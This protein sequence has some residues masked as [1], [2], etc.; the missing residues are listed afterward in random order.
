MISTRSLFQTGFHVSPFRMGEDNISQADRDALLVK[1]DTAFRAA[2]AIDAFAARGVDK[3]VAPALSTKF[4]DLLGQA[5]N[6]V[7]TVAVIQSRLESQVPTDWV[8][9]AVERQRVNDYAAAIDQMTTIMNT[10]AAGAKPG[11]P[12]TTATPSN[13]ILGMPPA[14]VYIGGTVVG[15]GLLMLLLKP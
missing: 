3:V 14:A 5:S 7:G 11:Q 12:A 1:I 8:V 15:V 4:K 6:M 10:P 9:D 2:P 13:Q